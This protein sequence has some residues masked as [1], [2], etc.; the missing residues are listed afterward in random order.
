MVEVKKGQERRDKEA[1]SQGKARCFQR[2]GAEALRKTKQGGTLLTFAALIPIAIYRND[3]EWKR[4]T[5]R[6]AN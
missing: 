2:G 5:C 3:V 1:G 6:R 4:K